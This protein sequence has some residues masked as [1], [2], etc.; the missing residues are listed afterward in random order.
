MRRG[1]R[2]FGDL[3]APVSAVL[4]GEQILGGD[5]HVGGVGDVLKPVG[6][7]LLHGLELTVPRELAIAVVEVKSLKDVQCHQRNQ[8]LAAGRNFPDV[9]AAVV[10]LDWLDP[11]GRVACEVV[12]AQVTA[13][14]LGKARD[15]LGQ[16]ASV[17]AFAT[18]RGQLFKGMGLIG[19]AEQLACC[20][21]FA[22][23]Q[24][25]VEPGRQFGLAIGFVVPF[26]LLPL[27][28]HDRRNRESI[29]S[30]LDCGLEEFTK[31]KFAEA[32]R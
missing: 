18:R 7:C 21:G 24:K 27:M 19:V 1:L 3:P 16:R 30:E 10:Q 4:F 15:S 9:I 2:E 29:A 32:L 13:G 17:E 25:G 8:P 20:G 12:A 26:R 14:G 11:F 28:R 22:V 6:I 31:R 5:A 23:C